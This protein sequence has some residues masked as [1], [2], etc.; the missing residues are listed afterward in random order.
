MCGTA[1]RSSHCLPGFHRQDLLI[2]AVQPSCRATPEASTMR[3]L[4]TTSK[5]DDEFGGRNPFIVTLKPACCGVET[6]GIALVA[7]FGIAT[8]MVAS[9]WCGL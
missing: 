9:L 6:A 5:V 7:T 2:P 1:D 3:E 4:R 8:A